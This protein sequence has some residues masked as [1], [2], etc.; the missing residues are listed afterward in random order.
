[1]KFSYHTARI[2]ENTLKKFS[3]KLNPY[4]QKLEEIAQT[5]QYYL[6]ESFINLPFDAA[7]LE[8]IAALK[9]TL[10]TPN[11]KYI[12]VIGMGGSSLGT[13][14]IYTA[15]QSS[16]SELRKYP[17][18]IF[19]D[20]LNPNFSQE[21]QKLLATIGTP[22][23]IL[24]NAI[25][26]SGE[27]L[28]VKTNLK[29]ILNYIPNCKDRLIITTAKNSPLWKEYQTQKV[30]LL[31]IPSTIGGRYS[32]LSAVGLF[33]LLMANIDILQ[34]LEG[35][36][37][38]RKNS[39][40]KDPLKNMAVISAI[41]T[42]LN[43]KHKKTIAVNL[44]FDKRLETLGKWY[45][46]LLAES[47]GKK[48]KGITPLTSMGPED[49]HSTQQLYVGGPKDKFFT[50][51]KTAQKESDFVTKTYTA[52]INS[53]EENY[54]ARE[55]PFT[56][57]ELFDISPHTLGEFMQFKMFEILFLA[58]LLNVNPFDQPNVEEYKKKVIIP[59]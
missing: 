12:L 42:Y 10:Q 47:L 21:L 3:K 58:K 45:A 16:I 30:P 46:Q 15:L 37:K 24:I 18:M 19:V 20:T 39:L 48:G 22:E 4:I 11:L 52:I 54:K 34:L 57:I 43:Y 13:K 2:A 49:L 53:V 51:I 25:S 8:K 36:M 40:E 38:A 28:E 7:Q 23:E 32:A 27:T 41:T 1:M 31:E 5:P 56:E 55:I 9:T 59:A 14:A 35:A 50:I 17:K 26:K 29:F 33:P 44:F 6:P